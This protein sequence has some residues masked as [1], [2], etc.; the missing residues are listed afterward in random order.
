MLAKRRMLVTVLM[1][2]AFMAGFVYYLSTRSIQ[3]AVTI[4]LDVIVT[5]LL[6]RAKLFN[7]MGI[8]PPKKR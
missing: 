8:W 7:R 3:F 1:V 6:F 2:V 4:V 5:F